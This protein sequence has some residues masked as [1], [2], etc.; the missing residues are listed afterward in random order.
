VPSLFV[1]GFVS[2]SDSDDGGAARS[3][4]ARGLRDVAMIAGG[5]VSTEAA[6]VA[7]RLVG[8]VIPS[9]VLGGGREMSLDLYAL[10]RHRPVV[11]YFYPGCASA[12]EDEAQ[13]RAFRDL[14]LDF[15]ARHYSPVG[16]SSQSERSQRA[17]AFAIGATH[18]LLRDPE[19]L[20]ARELGL[21]TFS[22]DG[23]SW[24]QRL[25]LVASGARIAKVFFPVPSAA[26]SAAQVIA[27][28]T[29]H[30][31]PAVVED[32]DDAAG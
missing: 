20:L 7:E 30:Q 12:R 31:G 21:P 22:C 27:W 4:A 24:Y 13:H 2:P 29:L 8:L 23:A 14:H 6:A 16:V 5:A 11:L 9:V 17:S 32:D 18:R 25:M 10:A 15:E 1:A 19:L 28:L 3:G 26:R